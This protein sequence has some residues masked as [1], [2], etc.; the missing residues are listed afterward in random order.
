MSR[1]DNASEW[2]DFELQGVSWQHR[3]SPLPTQTLSRKGLLPPKLLEVTAQSQLAGQREPPLLKR[4]KPAER[5]QTRF[6]PE[7]RDRDT[8]STQRGWPAFA[9]HAR[10]SKIFAKNQFPK[11][12]HSETV[13]GAVT[14]ARTS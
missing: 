6:G 8:A 1:L 5:I 2:V 12:H 13:L 4:R 10:R 9:E 7:R 11:L 14:G 3:E